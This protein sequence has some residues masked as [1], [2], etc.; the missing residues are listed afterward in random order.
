[1]AG[2]APT[3]TVASPDPGVLVT[4]YAYDERGNRVTQTDAAGRSTRWTYD[5]MGREI[6]RTL[7]LGQVETKTYNEAGELTSVTDFTGK[8]TRW[9][10]DATGRVATIDYPNDADVSFA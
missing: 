4:T 3:Y 2:P 5:R 10:H 6:S 8:T 1:V 9:T 7:P